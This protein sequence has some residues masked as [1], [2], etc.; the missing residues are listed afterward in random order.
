MLEISELIKISKVVPLHPF[1]KEQMNQV[2]SKVELQ[3]GTEINFY[4]DEGPDENWDA[5]LEKLAKEFSRPRKHRKAAAEKTYTSADAIIP[6]QAFLAASQT[7]QFFTDIKSS[8]MTAPA[9]TVIPSQKPM[10]KSASYIDHLNSLRKLY[11]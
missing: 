11:E 1:N 3:T 5:P 7:Q 6:S 9:K 10:G 4:K 2:N 8:I